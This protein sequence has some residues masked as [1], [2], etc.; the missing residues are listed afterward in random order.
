MRV[1]VLYTNP[2][3]S[4]R[5]TIDDHLH[6]FEKYVEGVTFYYCN[7]LLDLPFYLKW[8]QYDGIILHYTLLAQR[9]CL[10]YWAHRYHKACLEIANLSGV[11]VAIPQDEYAHT[12]E[13]NRLFKAIGVESIYTCAYPIDYQKL[14]PREESGLKHYFTTYTGFVDEETLDSIKTLHQ[15]GA[16][17]TID[18]GYRARRIPYWLGSHGQLKGDVADAFLAHEGLAT[19]SS[20]IS[21][22]PSDVFY[23]K[24]WM[25]FLLR[26]RTVL[27]CLGGASLHDPEG[28]IRHKVEE[29]VK[30]HPEAGFKEVEK[31]CFPGLDNDLHLFALSPRHFECAMTKTCQVLIEGDYDGVFLPDIH[32]I[33]LKKDFSNI[34]EVL[35][36]VKDKALCEQ[37]AERTY[38]DV[39]LS[40]KYTYRAFADQVISHIRE[41]SQNV[42]RGPMT[43]KERVLFSLADR[44]LLWKGKREVSLIKFFNLWTKWTYKN[45]RKW[46]RS[47]EKKLKVISF[48]NRNGP[49]NSEV[50]QKD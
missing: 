25:R 49:F 34:S 37:M 27:G 29:Y 3:L 26:C 33:E 5:K 28:V 23:G 9:W 42:V 21:T 36:K 15:E 43:F 47:I 1:L 7:V 35:E 45:P 32:F 30:L 8:I 11:K 44:L 39:I 18:M 41:L 17:R 31:A 2:E 48:R 50:R 6:C 16:P 10:G 40:E 12:N 14:Y 20:D 22:R 38:R 19:I 4:R 13:L 46:K 24:D